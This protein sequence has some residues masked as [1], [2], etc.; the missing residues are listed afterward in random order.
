MRLKR[1]LLLNGF[2]HHIANLKIFTVVVEATKANRKQQETPLFFKIG[3]T[4]SSL[5][6]K[7][8]KLQ[9]HFL[10]IYIGETG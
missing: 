8:T 7:L 2:A 4:N 5:K 3:F 10:V 9:A 1:H 6:Q